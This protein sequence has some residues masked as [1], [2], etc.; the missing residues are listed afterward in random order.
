MFTSI[1][2]ISGLDERAK[3]ND[4]GETELR[5]LAREQLKQQNIEF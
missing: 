5:K 2:T 4:N 3:D 1:N